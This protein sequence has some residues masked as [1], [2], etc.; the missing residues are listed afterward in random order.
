MKDVAKVKGFPDYQVTRTGEVYSIKRSDEP[1]KLRGSIWQG[2]AKVALRANG[3]STTIAIHRLVAGAFL[4]KPKNCNV[5]NHKDGNKLNNNVSNLEWT[6]HRGNSAHY[7]A[8]IAPTLTA[9][10]AKKKKD[11]LETKLSVVNFAYA[12][13]KDTNPE[14]FI[15]VYRAAF[16]E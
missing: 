9:K 4:P 15:K 7:S 13:Y 10:R 2:Y 16:A 1:S 14:E 8:T 11:L 12:A 5:V 3:K 6:T